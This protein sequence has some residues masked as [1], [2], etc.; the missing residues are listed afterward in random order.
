M[1][2]KIREDRLRRLLTKHD[3]KLLKTPAR[4]WFREYYGPG[5]MIINTLNNTIVSG[6]YWRE[7]QDTLEGAEAFANTLVS[8]QSSRRA[9]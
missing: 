9:A 7:Y 6:C 2:T 5:Y 3:H 4:S 1:S 8:Q